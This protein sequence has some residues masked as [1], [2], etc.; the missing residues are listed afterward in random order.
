MKRCNFLII[1]IILLLIAAFILSS[2]INNIKTEN[3]NNSAC[4]C[5]NKQNEKSGV[6]T[7]CDSYKLSD[8]YA[9]CIDKNIVIPQ[10][11]MDGISNTIKGYDIYKPEINAPIYDIGEI[12]L[13]NN[14][15][16]PRGYNSS[17]NINDINKN[18]KE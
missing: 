3:F 1:I 5:S 2:K 11:Y 15:R 13:F 18:I 14:P 16:I 12:N 4:V 17:V 6:K 9:K 8:I 10:R 7:S